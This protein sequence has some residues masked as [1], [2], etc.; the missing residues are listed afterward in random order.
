M[1]SPVGVNIGSMVMIDLTSRGTIQ[2]VDVFLLSKIGLKPRSLAVTTQEYQDVGI[3]PNV[4]YMDEDDARL[5]MTV[6]DKKMAILFG[7]R[8]AETSVRVGP[9][10]LF[11][12]GEGELRGFEVDL[13]RLL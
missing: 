10:V 9:S 3:R 4:S 13:S 1:P 2:S 8:G 11:L 5:S 12:L 6:Y 7:R